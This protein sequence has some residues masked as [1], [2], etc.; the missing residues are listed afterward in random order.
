M[1]AASDTGE[2][3]KAMAARLFGAGAIAFVAKAGGAALSYV[4]FVVFARLLAPDQYG[5][6]AFAF[7]LANAMSTIAGLGAATAILR[8]WPQHMVQGQPA[9]ARGSAVTGG[10]VTLAATLLCAGLL[11]AAA[12]LIARV[13][14]SADTLHLLVMALSVPLIALSEY[15]ASLLRAMGKTFLS[16]MPRDVIWRIMI[17][18]AA[19]SGIASG[20]HFSAATALAITTATLLAVVV[21][22]T[23]YALRQVNHQAPAPAASDLPLWRGATLPLWGAGILYVLV[24]QFDVV[25]AGIYLT[26]AETGAY[27]AAQKTA[28]LLTLLLI[29][30]NLVAGPLIATYYH[31]GDIAKLQR[32][33]NIIAVA[34]A[35]PTPFGLIFLAIAGSF[36]LGLFGAGFVAF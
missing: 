19:L 32:M 34:V 20:L 14:G 5:H 18:I 11:A 26:P 30:G 28:G 22:Q 8:F 21:P 9:L 29:A 10:G 27:F 17:I 25:I 1:S 4:I 13:S 12:P 16:L 6:F 31:A 35:A 23:P 24:Q 2:S 36:L 15:V 7:N 3:L 33:T